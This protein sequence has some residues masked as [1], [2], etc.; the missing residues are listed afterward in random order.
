MTFSGQSS[1]L[2]YLELIR[3]MAPNS[4]LGSGPSNW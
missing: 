1:Y 4:P 2:A 3:F